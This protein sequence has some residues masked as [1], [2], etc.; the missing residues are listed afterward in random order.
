MTK[1]KFNIF[2]CRA[3]DILAKDVISESGSILAAENLVLNDFII[4]KL[5]RL[6]I[7]AVWLY[8]KQTNTYSYYDKN[9]KVIDNYNNTVHDTKKFFTRLSNGKSLDTKLLS[10]VTQNIQ[11]NM[12]NSDIILQH[13]REIKT[14]DDY[15]Y[16]HSVNV[17]FYAMLIGKRMQMKDSSILELIQ[18]GVLHDIGKV[19]IPNLLLNKP[20]KLSNTEF[21]QI[22]EH[23]RL[24][25]EILRGSTQ[26]NNSVK[27][28]ILMHHERMDGS[29]YPL[30]LLGNSID[31]YAKI[32]AVADVYDAM[33]SDRPYKNK[34]TP[35]DALRMFTTSGIREF[36][37]NVVNSFILNF[38]TYF[39]GEK[40]VL[41]NDQIGEIVYLPPNEIFNPIIMVN[42]SILKISS[43]SG[44][45]IVSIL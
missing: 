16:S 45:K 33:T 34:V 5:K 20:D 39:L 44:P 10:Q 43:Y 18:A 13:L 40:V 31:L 6:G 15:T 42:S 8:K 12:D 36:D 30:G 29:G 35:F 25:Y 17:G 23:S 24:G 22:K 1:L 28:S 37:T 7:P 14:H 26:L 4:S 41:D 27:N 2:D 9:K 19:K 21:E 38:S 3:G 32:I 11:A